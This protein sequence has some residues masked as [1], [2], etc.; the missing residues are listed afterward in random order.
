MVL[1]WVCKSDIITHNK[2]IRSRFASRTYSMGLGGAVNAGLIGAIVGGLHWILKTAREGANLAHEV[3]FACT[4]FARVTKTFQQDDDC[5]QWSLFLAGF[6]VGSLC[7]WIITFCACRRTRFL[8]STPTVTTSC[9]TFPLRAT[10][11]IVEEQV[12]A[13][14]KVRRRKSSSQLALGR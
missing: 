10:A 4:D 9:A 14:V 3:K 13:D 8:L 11:L 5:F 7:S 6:I 12:S 2:I 1:K